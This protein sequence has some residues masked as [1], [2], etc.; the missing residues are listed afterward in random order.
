MMAMQFAE[1]TKQSFAH[2]I[3]TEIQRMDRRMDELERL[4]LTH[5]H[6]LTGSET[7]R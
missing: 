5:K 3:K 2:S 7:K 1:K 6:H 4:L